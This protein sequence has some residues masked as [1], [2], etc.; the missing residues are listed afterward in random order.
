[1]LGFLVQW[2]T[3]LT[4]AMFPVLVLMYV[5]LARTEEQAAI[6]EFGDAYRK[7][8]AEVPGFV[9]RWDRFAGGSV[10]GS[11]ETE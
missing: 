10:G 6:A 5:R 3:L 8:M 11:A 9:P 7:Y 2:P 4:L 1:M